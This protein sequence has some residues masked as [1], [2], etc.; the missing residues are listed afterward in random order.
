[1][2]SYHCHSFEVF[3]RIPPDD[4]NKEHFLEDIKDTDSANADFCAWA[5]GSQTNPGKQHADMIVDFRSQECVIAAITFHQVE[6][7]I[8]DKRAP[9]MEDCIQWL[10]AFITK[11]E[12]QARLRAFYIFNTDFSPKANLPFPMLTVTDS[13]EFEDA[14]V[15]G[16]TIELPSHK[17]IKR[18]TIQRDSQGT[19]LNLRMLKELGLKDFN[20]ETQLEELSPFI[21]KFI[22]NREQS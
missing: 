21:G 13:S 2:E 4:F 12:V 22:R 6:A 10:S 18:I 17:E 14:I 1:M 8:E 15:T 20:L 11:N 9:Y 3:L 19:S 7:N 16:I 5:F